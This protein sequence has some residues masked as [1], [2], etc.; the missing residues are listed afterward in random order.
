MENES[1]SVCGVQ[2]PSVRLWLTLALG[3]LGAWFCDGG[4]IQYFPIPFIGIK[5]MAAGGWMAVMLLGV[6]LLHRTEKE[7]FPLRQ[8]EEKPEERSRA[9]KMLRHIVFAL[10]APYFLYAS[11]PAGDS[12]TSSLIIIFTRAAF[13]VFPFMFAMGIAFCLEQHHLRQI[14]NL[15]F[16]LSIWTWLGCSLLFLL[17]PPRE[18]PHIPQIRGVLKAGKL[19]ILLT[20]IMIATA[21]MLLILS[22]PFIFFMI[23]LAAPILLL[24]FACAWLLCSLFLLLSPVP[25][26]RCKANQPEAIKAHPVRIA[27]A[28][29]VALAPLATIGFYPFLSLVTG[30]LFNSHFSHANAGFTLDQPTIGKL[31]LFFTIFAIMMF[32]FVI[33]ARGISDRQTRLGYWAFT[34]PTALIGLCLLSIL[35]DTFC[36]LILYIRDMGFTLTRI[37]GLIYGLISY[38]IVLTLLCW[39]LWPP[40]FCACKDSNSPIRRQG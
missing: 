7:G 24:H 32:L 22:S 31:F 1:V 2:C 16:S 11:R 3:I 4:N 33:V 29:I 38:I 30:Q 35:T 23:I 13:A 8:S 19:G 20:V 26:Y 25:A 14:G 9:K 34:I 10:A 18:Y 39:A 17:S 40:E 15:Y 6:L 28:M 37:C 27:V 12:R 21:G 5:W 36:V